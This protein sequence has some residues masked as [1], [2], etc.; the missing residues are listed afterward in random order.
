MEGKQNDDYIFYVLIAF[1]GLVSFIVK[2]V[3]EKGINKY[4][5][6]QFKEMRADLIMKFNKFKSKFYVW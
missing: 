3:E 6:S 4:I 1:F 2:K 5:R